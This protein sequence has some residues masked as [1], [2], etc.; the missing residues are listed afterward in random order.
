MAASTALRACSALSCNLS[1]PG[2]VDDNSLATLRI[3]ADPRKSVEDVFAG[4]LTEHTILVVGEK[5]DVLRAIAF[6]LR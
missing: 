3:F 5:D 6:D 4:R 2:I 1:V